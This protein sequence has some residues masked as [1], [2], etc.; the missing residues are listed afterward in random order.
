MTDGDVSLPVERARSAGAYD[1]LRRR[2]LLG[3]YPLAERL[4]EVGLAEQLG[5]SRTPIREA[6]LRLEA[7]GLVER[8]PPRGF[9]PR[10]PNLAGVRHL[11]ELRTIL[12]LQALMLP[13]S[14]GRTH[15]HGALEAI[16]ADWVALAEEM[17]PPD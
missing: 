12:E 7:E 13:R 8:R 11:Y 9:Y 6:L 16:Q 10:S 14:H 3:G 1:Q 17:P 15:D 5:I 2:L 4:T